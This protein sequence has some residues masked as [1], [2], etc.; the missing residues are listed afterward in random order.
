ME[1]CTVAL[2]ST[3]K[4]SSLGIFNVMLYYAMLCSLHIK[5]EFIA[6]I[7]HEIC[8]SYFSITCSKLLKRSAAAVI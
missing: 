1:R 4:T 5:T 3:A 6:F 8:S 2:F 7:C